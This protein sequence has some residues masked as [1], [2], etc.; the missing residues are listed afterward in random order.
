MDVCVIG[1]TAVLVHFTALK[2]C[3]AILNTSLA[4]DPNFALL[5]GWRIVFVAAFVA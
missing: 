5:A 4:S 1:N 2:N 3:G